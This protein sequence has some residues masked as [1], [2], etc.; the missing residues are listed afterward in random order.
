MDPATVYIDLLLV[1]RA[2]ATA[3]VAKL[4]P[5]VIRLE[6]DSLSPIELVPRFSAELNPW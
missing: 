5:K 6:T 1:A 2:L 4:D 3:F